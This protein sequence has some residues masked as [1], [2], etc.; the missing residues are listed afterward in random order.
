MVPGQSFMW[1]WDSMRALIEQEGKAMRVSGF[2]FVV[3]SDLV[4]P[5]KKIPPK[6]SHD[7]SISTKTFRIPRHTAS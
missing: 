7:P 2:A 1:F 5:N 4:P 6:S 3:S